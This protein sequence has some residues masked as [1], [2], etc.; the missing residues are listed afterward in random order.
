VI[1]TWKA[2][3]NIV[4]GV[5]T[6]VRRGAIVIACACALISGCAKK[7]HVR[8]VSTPRIDS[9]ETGIASWYGYPY[10]GRRAAN[11]EIYD[12]EKLT[13]AHRTLPFGTWVEVHNLNNEKEITVRITDRGPFVD[14]RIIDLSKAAARAIDMI[15]PGVAKVKIRIVSAPPDVPA[16]DVYAVQVGAFADKSRAERLRAKLAAEYQTARLV[17]RAG[18]PPVWRVL[19]GSEPTIDGA[20]ELRDRIQLSGLPA[21]VVRLDEPATAATAPIDE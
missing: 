18:T 11:G 10:H 14:G 15:G 4:G 1:S 19:A 17:F 16:S 20:N 2:N 6:A 13:A 5:P 21:L 9:V 3:S 12:M 7:K 8:T